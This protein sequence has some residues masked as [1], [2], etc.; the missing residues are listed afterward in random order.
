MTAVQFNNRVTDIQ[1]KLFHYAKTLTYNEEEARDLLQDSLL[2]ALNFKHKFVENTNFNAWMHVIMRNTFIN[3]YRKKSRTSKNDTS[4][5]EVVYLSN[6]HY[7]RETPEMH[8]SLVHINKTIEQLEHDLKTPFQMHVF[9]Y[10]YKEIAEKLNLPIGT[11]K[12]RIS[13]AR[14]KLQNMIM[15]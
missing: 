9:G 5:D 4:M 15:N 6:Y 8:L 11:V 13:F 2:R 3:D 7:T 10:K 12:S 14:K 1:E